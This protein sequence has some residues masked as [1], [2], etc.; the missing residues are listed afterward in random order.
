MAGS[1]H[2]VRHWSQGGECLIRR[3]SALRLVVGVLELLDPIDDKP[4]V[5]VP[6]PSRVSGSKR[7]MIGNN[8]RSTPADEHNSEQPDKDDCC[9]SSHE[10]TLAGLRRHRPAVISLAC[11]TLMLRHGI[12]FQMVNW[13]T[14]TR[15]R[16]GNTSRGITS[17]LNLEASAYP[18]EHRGSVG[19]VRPSVLIGGSRCS[20]EPAPADR[21]QGDS[22][23]WLVRTR[24]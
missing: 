10:S 7:F 17:R 23:K 24:P 20:S 3:T 13:S 9:A 4:K 11:F 19:S 6:H 14:L 18:R 8:H 22:P 5:V 12:S 21:W 1:Q 16:L 15:P 2:A